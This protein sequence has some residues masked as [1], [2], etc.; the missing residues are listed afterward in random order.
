MVTSKASRLRLAMIAATVMLGLPQLAQAGGIDTSGASNLPFSINSAQVM[1]MTGGGL[2]FNIAP[3]TMG[4]TLNQ[5]Q[6]WSQSAGAAVYMQYSNPNGQVVIGGQPNASNNLVVNGETIGNLAPASYGQFRMYN[7]TYGSM[8]RNDGG[9]TYL[10]LTNANDGYGIWN[11]L[12]PFY[13]ND[14]TGAV[15]MG[16]SL[17]VSSDATN[18][19][20][21]NG[22]ALVVSNGNLHVAAGSIQVAGDATCNAS[23]AGTISFANGQFL[24]CNGTSWTSL[25]QTAPPNKSAGASFAGPYGNSSCGFYTDSAGTIH[26][27]V[28]QANGTANYDSTSKVIVGANAVYEG[29]SNFF[30]YAYTCT[31]DKDGM[32]WAFS[33]QIC[34]TYHSVGCGAG[35]VP[36]Q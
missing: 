29:N 11:G 12:R 7:A 22:A 16:N 30:D 26:Q 23:K 36:W 9:N 27:T 6:I 14:A 34:N 4:L 19:A 33:Q 25:S 2:A 10:L 21:N 28:A 15:T 32:S 24:G 20:A 17:S 31:A 3:A 18:L 13:V 1:D 8:W 35:F 5:N